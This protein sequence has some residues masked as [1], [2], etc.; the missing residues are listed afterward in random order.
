MNDSAEAQKDVIKTVTKTL[1]NMPFERLLTLFL[2]GACRHTGIPGQGDLEL[3]AVKIECVALDTYR[4]SF[5]VV[6]ECPVERGSWVVANT[7]EVMSVAA[8]VWGHIGGA[9]L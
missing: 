1:N 8:P 2:K 5:R 9:Y 3:E 7:I 6:S 4:F